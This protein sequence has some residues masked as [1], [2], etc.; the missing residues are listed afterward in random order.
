M[1]LDKYKGRNDYEEIINN[2]IGGTDSSKWDLGSRNGA[3]DKS[4]GADGAG[5]GATQGG[6]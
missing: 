4:V 3:Q 6:S 1:L 5:S 2:C